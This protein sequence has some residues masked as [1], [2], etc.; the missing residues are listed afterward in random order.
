LAPSRDRVPAGNSRF[1]STRLSIVAGVGSRD[2]HTKRRSFE[3]LAQAYWRPVYKY[4]RLRWHADPEEAED[5]TQELFARAFEK[6]Y[7]RPYDP[8]RARFRT[9]LRTCVDGLVANERQSARRLK[10][11]GGATLVPFD[12]VAAELELGRQDPVVTDDEEYFRQ[13]WIRG[14]F[15]S[16]VETLRQRCEARGRLEWYDVFVRYDL[17]DGP[18]AERPT[19]RELGEALG[20]SVTDVTNRLAAMRRQFRG[21]VVEQLEAQCGGPDEVEAE[22]TYLF[23]RGAP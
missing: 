17:H 4:L 22:L 20:V 3:A 12:F 18:S 2:P 15:G 19:Y 14:L 11:G 13:E 1:P 16:A 6:D 21:I 7:F 9:Y 23:G 5:L 10:R 8:G